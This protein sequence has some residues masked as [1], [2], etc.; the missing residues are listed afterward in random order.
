MLIWMT[1][2]IIMII[3]I[4]ALFSQNENRD[5]SEAQDKEIIQRHREEVDTKT[6]GFKAAN[7][8]VQTKSKLN[9]AEINV[10]K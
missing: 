10:L 5:K 9:V 7:T 8:L 3:I 2:L 4:N 1:I 6:N